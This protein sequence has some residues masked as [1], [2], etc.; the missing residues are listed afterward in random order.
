MTAGATD[1]DQAPPA[2]A[3]R[4]RLLPEQVGIFRKELT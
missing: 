3:T 2:P 4:T 1:A